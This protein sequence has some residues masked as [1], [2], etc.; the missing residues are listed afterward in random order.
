MRV[1]TRDVRFAMRRSE[2]RNA[3]YEISYEEK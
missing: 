1:G 3:G 2:G